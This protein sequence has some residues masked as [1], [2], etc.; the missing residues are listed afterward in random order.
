MDSVTNHFLCYGLFNLTVL[1]KAFGIS[2]PEVIHKPALRAADR[3]MKTCPKGERISRF[4]GRHSL[5]P[6]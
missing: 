3:P 5:A 4:P 6:D 2:V 1:L